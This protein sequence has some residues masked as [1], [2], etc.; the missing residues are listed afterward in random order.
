MPG[1][2]K[3]QQVEEERS[4]E[5][6]QVRNHSL[7]PQVD[8]TRDSSRL[9]SSQTHLI[10]SVIIALNR[11]K[12]ANHGNGTTPCVRLSEANPSSRTRP[13]VSIPIACL[14]HDDRAARRLLF[15]GTVLISQD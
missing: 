2:K 9:I 12:V 4:H 1:P 13:I 5:R 10:S 15:L 8:R 11:E 6:H 3:S 14:R 7:Q